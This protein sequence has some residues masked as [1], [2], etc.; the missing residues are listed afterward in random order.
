M[1][2]SP[3]KKNSSFLE[4]PTT[5]LLAKG[6]ADGKLSIGGPRFK[7]QIEPLVAVT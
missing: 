3:L 6:G 7:V 1:A 2:H 5:Q 4:V